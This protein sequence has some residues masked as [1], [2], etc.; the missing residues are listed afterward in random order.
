[1][2]DN[3]MWLIHKPSELGILLGKRLAWG[4]YSSLDPDYLQK[5]YTYLSKK[6]SCTGD[7]D[8]FILAQE[9]CK[10]SSCFDDWIY[11]E[12]KVSGFRVF[13]FINKEE[14]RK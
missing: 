4:W 14:R 2:A 8:D 5:F 12:K 10:N 13:E 11:T 1:M 9:D 6:E 3:R 7:Q